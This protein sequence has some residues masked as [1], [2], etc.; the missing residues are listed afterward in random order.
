MSKT[1]ETRES[2]IG[3]TAR[4]GNGEMMTII[5]YRAYSDIDIRFNESGY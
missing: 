5:A 4:A 1:S 3:E 2:R